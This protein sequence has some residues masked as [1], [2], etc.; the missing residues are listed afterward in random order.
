MC[1]VSLGMISG[2]A[3]MKLHEMRS[4]NLYARASWSQPDSS[5]FSFEVSWLIK[6]A[7]PAASGEAG[8]EIPAKSGK[9]V[10]RPGLTGPLR[11]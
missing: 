2:I 8:R 5:V 10:A 6:L 7:A 9:R 11:M 1:Q 3:R 4:L